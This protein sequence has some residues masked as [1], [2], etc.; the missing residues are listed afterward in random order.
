MLFFSIKKSILLSKISKEYNFKSFSIEK[1]IQSSINN[2]KNVLL[3]KLFELLKSDKKTTQL[4]SLYNRDFN[5]IRKIITVLEKTGA[6]QIVKGHYV[7]ISSVSFLAQLEFI[8]SNWDGENF[9]IHNLDEN[10][11]NMK[12]SYI[13][14]Q[15]FE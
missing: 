3:E 14:L 12:V 8:L 2:N 1:M 11:S 15:S 13:L 4:L 5:D 9:K 6:G 10:N 7:P